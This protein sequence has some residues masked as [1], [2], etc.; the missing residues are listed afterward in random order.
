MEKHPNIQKS[1]FNEKKTL[2]EIYTDYIE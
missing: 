1:D 2:Y